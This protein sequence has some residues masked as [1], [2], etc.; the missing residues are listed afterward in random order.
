[1]IY[2]SSLT[3]IVISFFRASLL[4]VALLSTFYVHFSS[5]LPLLSELLVSCFLLS[6]IVFACKKMSSHEYER[7][8]QPN[9]LPEQEASST[10]MQN[11][12]SNALDRSQESDLTMN[13]LFELDSISMDEEVEF[14]VTSLNKLISSSSPSSCDELALEDVDEDYMIEIP[15]SEER[16][17]FELNEGDNLEAELVNLVSDMNDIGGED[18]LI[19]ID[20][21]MGSI[22]HSVLGV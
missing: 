8:V 5:S 10:K 1:M 14:E 16:V 11:G 4:F 21:S 9:K 20:I 22:R 6:N 3:L 18:N 19:E 2:H 12:D 7:N 15:L 13:S 17:S